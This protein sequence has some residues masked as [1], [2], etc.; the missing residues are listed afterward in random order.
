MPASNF[1]EKVVF[2]SFLENKAYTPP[3]KTFLA[4]TENEPTKLMTGTELGEAAK[5]AELTY[6][7]YARVELKGEAATWEYTAGGA[8]TAGKLVNKAAVTLK[9]NT[10]T[11]GKSL[12]VWFAI[13]DAVT[14]G[15]VLFYGKLTE[16]LNI[17][18]TITKLEVEAKKLEILAE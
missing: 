14:A 10:G 15:N 8:Q 17:T 7:G 4:L 6:E 13:C 11:T 2:E 12:A 3:T 1:A 5:G 9:L 16:S 18:K